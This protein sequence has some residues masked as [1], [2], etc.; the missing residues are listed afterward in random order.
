MAELID[1]R[2]GAKKRNRLAVVL[3]GTGFIGSN[4]VERLKNEG[5]YVIAADINPEKGD[6]NITKADEFYK[7]DLRDKDACLKVIPF[8]ADRVYQLAAD[9]G[10]AGY[11]FTGDH[12][13]AVMTNS[14]LVNLN[15]AMACTIMKVKKIFWSSSACAYPEDIQMDPNNAGLKEEY[16]YPANPDSEYGWEKLFSE[17]LWLAYNRNEGLDVRIARFHNIYGPL[18]AYSTSRAK[19]PAAISY[20][21]LTNKDKVQIWGDGKQTRSFLY[22]EDCLDAIE[23]L[24]TSETFRGPV[25]IGSEEII[26]IGDFTRMIMDICDSEAEVENIEGPQ[27]VRGRN[28]N[29]NLIKKELGWSPN[30]TLRDGIEE[31]IQWIRYDMNRIFSE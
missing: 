20:K 15:V 23:R 3:G 14:V 9:M 11:I 4:L 18:S 8:E 2:K 19:A 5:W 7:V 22:I 29:N 31:L 16:A 28:S 12:D 24:M 10:G 13:A 21:V 1:K 30:Y 17:R 27:G 25:N 6:P 26:S